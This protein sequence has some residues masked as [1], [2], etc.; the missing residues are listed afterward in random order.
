LLLLG[1][2]VCIAYCVAVCGLL[3]KYLLFCHNYFLRDCKV[4]KKH[5]IRQVF[6]YITEKESPHVTEKESARY[7]KRVRSLRKNAVLTTFLSKF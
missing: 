7:G 5:A 3:G 1:A 2:S 6:E 4:T